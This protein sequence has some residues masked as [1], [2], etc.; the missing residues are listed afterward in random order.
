VPAAALAATCASVRKGRRLMLTLGNAP[1]LAH[2]GYHSSIGA[3]R[4]EA[5]GQSVDL[6][7]EVDHFPGAL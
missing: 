7:D 3:H 2:P 5:V 6:V 1:K 4:A